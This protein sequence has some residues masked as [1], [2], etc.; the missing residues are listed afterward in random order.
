MAS[1]RVDPDLLTSHYA[2]MVA[3]NRLRMIVYSVQNSFYGDK[4]II[5]NKWIPIEQQ[6]FGI[7]FFHI[8]GQN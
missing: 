1:C 2:E 7:M 6:F 3:S 4:M 8:W 5:D